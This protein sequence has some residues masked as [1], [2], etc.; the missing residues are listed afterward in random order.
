MWRSWQGALPGSITPR[1]CNRSFEPLSHFLG[2][3]P[4]NLGVAAI[5][6]KLDENGALDLQ[7]REKLIE[8][9]GDHKVP[10]R[11]R[12]TDRRAREPGPDCLRDRRKLVGL[13]DHVVPLL[14]S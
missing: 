1:C 12:Q 3:A 4:A 14:M 6:E 13:P 2:E 5:G 11:S 10:D 9:A 7:Y 8:E